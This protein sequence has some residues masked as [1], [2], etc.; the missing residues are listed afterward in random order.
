DIG[1]FVHN[2]TYYSAP[3][4]V[5]SHTLDSEAR[6]YD[7]N[8]KL[9]DIGYGAGDTDLTINDWNGVFDLLR[10][11]A[12]TFAAQLLQRPFRQEERAAILTIAAE[13]KIAAAELTTALDKSKQAND[14]RQKVQATFK[15]ADDKKTAAQKANE[16]DP[17]DDTL[18]A[19][20]KAA[21]E[22]DTQDE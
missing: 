22:R 6:T 15:A 18:A 12:K 3:G 4:F 13:Y 2:G 21:L 9:L 7:E 8:G 20:K 5:C 1:A 19:Y 11:E 10:P 14:A 16:K 17:S